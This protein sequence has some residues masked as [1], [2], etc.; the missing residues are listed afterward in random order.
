MREA[1]S[2]AGLSLKSDERV[3]ML[4]KVLTEKFDRDIAVIDVFGFFS[5]LVDGTE[6]HSHAALAEPLIQDKPIIDDESLADRIPVL[7][8]LDNGRLIFGPQGSRPE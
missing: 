6:D 1:L 2:L 7:G 3:V 4:G 5:A 8:I